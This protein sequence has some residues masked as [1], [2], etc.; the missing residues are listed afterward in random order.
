M[1]A[2]VKAGLVELAE[3]VA[4][5]FVGP[6]TV[7]VTIRHEG[8]RHEESPWIR[9]GWETAPEILAEFEMRKFVRSIETGIR[10][11]RRPDVRKPISLI[12]WGSD[13]I[14]AVVYLRAVPSKFG[15]FYVWEHDGARVLEDPWPRKSGVRGV[16][17]RNA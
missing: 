12:V 8:W 16:G 11:R 14:G 4:P 1:S 7:R 9:G 5:P 6:C 13:R 15:S 10:L 17:G 3:Y 2:A